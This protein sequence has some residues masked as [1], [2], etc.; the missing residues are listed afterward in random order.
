MCAVYALRHVPLRGAHHSIVAQGNVSRKTLS[1]GTWDL[2]NSEILARNEEKH[3]IP[4]IPR[5]VDLRPISLVSRIRGG[6]QSETP[7]IPYIWTIEVLGKECTH[8]TREFQRS[9]DPGIS[10]QPPQQTSRGVGRKSLDFRISG[11]HVVCVC[12]PFP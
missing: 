12:I 5:S 8:K 10:D 9:G 3:E 4:E 1:S 2:V 7:H 11:I 6:N